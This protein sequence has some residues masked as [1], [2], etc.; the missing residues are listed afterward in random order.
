MKGNRIVLCISLLIVM[1]FSTVHIQAVF[2]ASAEEIRNRL[3]NA[4]RIKNNQTQIETGNDPC[5]QGL[6]LLGIRSW[7]PGKAPSDYLPPDHEIRQNIDRFNQQNGGQFKNVENLW[8]QTFEA[9]EELE[10]LENELVGK[11]SANWKNEQEKNSAESQLNS[12]KEAVTRIEKEIQEINKNISETSRDGGDTESLKASLASAQ[13]RLANAK[14]KQ[15]EANTA[16]T[17]AQSNLRTSQQE[18]KETEGKKASK[19]SEYESASQRAR[20]ADEALKPV[21]QQYFE[22]ELQASTVCQ[23]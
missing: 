19:N 6:V 21:R 9:R 20:S 4:Q 22:M 17:A 13:K 5:S 12:A 16:F 2:G 23:D 10:D 3:E 8:N 15:N 7:E 11:Q 18:L 1:F 14:A